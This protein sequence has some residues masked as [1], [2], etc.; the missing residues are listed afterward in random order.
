[1]LKYL[2]LFSIAYCLSFRT[3]VLHHCTFKTPAL[4]V[5]MSGMERLLC[6]F[7]MRKGVKSGALSFAPQFKVHH[8][9][10]LELEPGIRRDY[11]N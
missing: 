5:V 10:V 3:Y 7:Q 1:M 8:I 2:L 9:I 6:A 4:R 11:K